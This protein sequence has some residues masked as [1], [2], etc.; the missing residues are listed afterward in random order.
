MLKNEKKVAQ[1]QIVLDRLLAE[2]VTMTEEQAAMIATHTLQIKSD[3]GKSELQIQTKIY[4]ELQHIIEEWVLSKAR[5][6]VGADPKVAR[7]EVLKGLVGL[8]K[9]EN[10]AYVAKIVETQMFA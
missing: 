7:A 2:G 8:N 5:A 6:I 3:K 4:K 10:Q 9:P 1:L